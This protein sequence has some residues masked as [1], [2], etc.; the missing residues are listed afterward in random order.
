LCFLRRGETEAILKELGNIPSER[1]RLIIVVMGRANTSRQDF[2]RKV[3]IISIEQEAL[4]DRRMACLTSAISAGGKN[5]KEGGLERESK[6]GED[7]GSV[8]KEEESFKIFWWK[9]LRKEFARE[10][11]DVELGRISSDLRER[12]VSSKDQSFLG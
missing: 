8:T 12:R 3:G 7:E 10:R 5:E 1:A 11:G 9:K 4:D 2:S 6:W